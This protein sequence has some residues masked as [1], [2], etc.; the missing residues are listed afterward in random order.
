MH[1]LL[2]IAFLKAMAHTACIIDVKQKGENVSFQMKPDAKA[3]VD[4]IEDVLKEFDGELSLR[5]GE[6]PTFV[7]NLENTKKKQRLG[8]IESCIGALNGLIM[9]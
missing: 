8:K 6:V 9:R 7:L 3:D 4:R 2:Y 5:A 1:N